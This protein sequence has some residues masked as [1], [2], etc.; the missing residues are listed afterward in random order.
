MLCPLLKWDG[1]HLFLLKSFFFFFSEPAN[2]GFFTVR[3]DRMDIIQQYVGMEMLQ[4]AIQWPRVDP[5]SC[6]RV[7]HFVLMHAGESVGMR[8]YFAT[9]ETA[10]AA[11]SSDSHPD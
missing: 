8:G 10:L 1:Y 5:L 11:T 3:E 2:H 6:K 9:E 4:A 7:F